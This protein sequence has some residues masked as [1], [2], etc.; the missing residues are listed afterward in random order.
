MNEMLQPD[1]IFESQF[2]KLILFRD[3]EINKKNFIY[4][5]LFT[6]KCSQQKLKKRTA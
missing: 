4:Y 2:F 6:G 3:A 1:E 5:I